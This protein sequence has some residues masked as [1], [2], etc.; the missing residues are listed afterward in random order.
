LPWYNKYKRVVAIQH[1]T[2]INF[3]RLSNEIKY[4]L[5]LH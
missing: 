1:Y 2:K 4:K 3:L 5:D